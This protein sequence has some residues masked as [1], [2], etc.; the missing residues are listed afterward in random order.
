MLLARAATSGLNLRMHQAALFWSLSLAVLALGAWLVCPRGE[1]AL[2]AFDRFGLGLAHDL[3][4]NQRG[5]TLDRLMQAVTWLGSLALLLPLAAVAAWLLVRRGR[6]NEAGFVLLALIGA[7]VL[8]HLTKLW[9][10][11]PRP[12]LYLTDSLMPLDWSYPSAHS[13]QITALALALFLVAGRRR[14]VPL[15]VI[16]VIAVLLVGLSRI[17]LQVHFPSDVLVGLLA[18]AFWVFG[19][20]ALMF[21][22]PAKFDKDGVTGG[23]S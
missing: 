4:N 22:R 7:S 9:V 23:T 16:L 14:A 3:A 15:A 17:Y 19:L 20:H 18:G 21:S 1:C 10:M 11:R 6:R 13:M 12:D 8:S 5:V 2:S